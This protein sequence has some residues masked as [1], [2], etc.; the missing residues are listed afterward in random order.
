MNESNG[1]A[2]SIKPYTVKQLAEI[3]G[4]SSNIFKGWVEEITDKVGKKKGHY[5]TV[6][7]VTI[8]FDEIGAPPPPPVVKAKN[9]QAA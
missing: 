8:L 1:T 6:K 7:Q 3:Y 4:V 9:N 2:P 5:F